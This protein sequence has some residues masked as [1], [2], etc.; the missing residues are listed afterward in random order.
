MGAATLAVAVGTVALVAHGHYS[1]LAMKKSFSVEDEMQAE[2]MVYPITPYPLSR[3]R[4]L[5]L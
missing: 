3:T 4:T 1:S 5:V 2:R